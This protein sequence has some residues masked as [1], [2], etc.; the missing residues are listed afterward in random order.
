MHDTVRDPIADYH[1]LMATRKFLEAAEVM[2][3]AGDAARQGDLKDEAASFR[4]FMAI[5]LTLAGDLRAAEVAY[6]DAERDSPEDP[7]LKLRLA[8]FFL[9]DLGQPERALSKIQEGL[10][11]L[12]RDRM[13]YHEAQSSLGVIYARMGRLSDAAEAFRE[14]VRPEMLP[15]KEPRAYDLRLVMALAAKGVLLSECRLYVEN[16]LSLA[17]AQGDG[18]AAHA[19]RSALGA[20]ASAG[21]PPVS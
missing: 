18:G 7:L 4:V 9:D 16:L 20:I 14:L 11:I 5:A 1:A 10:P 21:G 13:T 17:E 12:L 19:A 6:L 8:N 3:R 15:G 2:R